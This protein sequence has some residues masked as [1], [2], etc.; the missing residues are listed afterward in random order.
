MVPWVEF[1]NFN[2]KVFD[3][4]KFLLPLVIQVHHAVCDGYHIGMFVAKFQSYI[5]QF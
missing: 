3:E 5:D 4:G 1:T 2:S